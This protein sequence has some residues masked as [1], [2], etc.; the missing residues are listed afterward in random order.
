MEEADAEAAESTVARHLL[1]SIRYFD[2]K[3]GY[4]KISAVHIDISAM[5]AEGGEPK[6]EDIMLLIDKQFISPTR[7]ERDKELEDELQALKTSKTDFPSAAIARALLVHKRKYGPGQKELAERSTRTFITQMITSQA[8]EHEVFAPFASKL[9]DQHALNS[10]R[11]SS[12][13]GRR[14]RPNHLG[15]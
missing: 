7:V 1:N 10:R 2:G 5:E 13:P 12:A 3:V 8:Q 11:S 15:Q 14:R 9:L 6:P 4:T